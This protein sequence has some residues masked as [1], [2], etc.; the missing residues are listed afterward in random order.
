MKRAKKDNFIK[1]I[2]SAD[3]KKP[4]ANFTT[5]VMGEISADLKNETAIDLR[6]KTLLRQQPIEKAPEYITD[7]V[8]YQI[9]AIGQI[10]AFSPLIS[11]KAWGLITAAIVIIV[12]MIVCTK[13]EATVSK[14]HQIS[15]LGSIDRIFHAIHPMYLVTIIMIS[16]L[17]YIDYFIDTRLAISKSGIQTQV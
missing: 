3:F 12:V 7:K 15:D 10:T 1:L 11:K 17:L 16:I 14:A 4:A 6:L 2:K 9:H 8:M 5:S 13:D